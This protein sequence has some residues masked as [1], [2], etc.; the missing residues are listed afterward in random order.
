MVIGD[1]LRKAE[2]Q[3]QLFQTHR[4]GLE[5]EWVHRPR[6]AYERLE[7]HLAQDVF[8]D[9]DP[10]R[11]LDEFH[12]RGGSLE[13]AAF[14]YVKDRLTA[15]GS[16]GATEGGLLYSLHELRRSPFI[17]NFED[18]IGKL[19]LQ[20]TR[21]ERASEQKLP[22]VLR[23]VD[24]ASCSSEPAAEPADIDVSIR[25]RL[26]HAEACEI[27]PA[28]VIEVELLVLLDNS[29]CIERRSEIESALRYAADDSGLRGQRHV[30]EDV[31][32]RC[33]SGHAFRHPN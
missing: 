4:F 17:G 11:D 30:F 20:P 16:V 22:G 14:G 12:P 2:A 31:L 32:L 6:I 10:R 9:V 29:F 5:N 7:A 25:V 15:L 33:N 26:R 21:G 28:A 27:E 24:K 1:P 3:K 13:Y 8:F 19:D 23:D 18:A